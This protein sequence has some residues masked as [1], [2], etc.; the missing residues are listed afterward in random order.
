[1]TRVRQALLTGGALLG[2]I[3]LLA[4]LA[5][6]V[7][8]VRPTVFRS[9]SMSPT[10][11]AGAL[12]LVHRVDARDISRGDVV[13]VTVADGSR[14]THRVVEVSVADDVATLHMRGDANAVTDPEPYRVTEADRVL[15]AVPRLGY[16]V[17]W[18][19]TGVG[20]LAL[21]MYAGFLLLVL[22]RPHPPR[23]TPAGR[24]VPTPGRRRAPKTRTRV[25]V[26]G[27]AALV[28]LGG[29]LELSHA[30]DGWAAWSDSSAVTGTTLGTHAVLPPTSVSCTGGGLLA[31]LT[32]SWPSMDPRYTYRAELVDSTGTVQRTDVVPESGQADY[33]VTYASADL[34]MG[35]FTVRVSSLLTASTTWT[36]PTT[37]SAG[38]SK[39]SSMPGPTTACG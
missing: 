4:A 26:V 16:A 17:E 25:R 14:L 18:L 9:G 22:V 30:S 24:S 36:S 32:Y 23:R 34:P 39:T 11:P 19:T 20:R 15:G 27:V 37:A 13:G 31:S 1:M 3:C 6:V 35:D 12:A 8:D 21:G 38:G 2:A 29:A 33:R 7:L 5:A 28:A 10:I